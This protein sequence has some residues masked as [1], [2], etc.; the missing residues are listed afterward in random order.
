VVITL[1]VQRTALDRE[2]E[3]ASKSV[4]FGAN[5]Q[6]GSFEGQ[7]P[8]H[9]HDRL[10]PVNAGCDGSGRARNAPAD[11]SVSSKGSN[12]I[13]VMVTCSTSSELCRRRQRPRTWLPSMLLP[14]LTSFC[15]PEHPCGGEK[16]GG[17]VRVVEG[18]G[19][20]TLPRRPRTPEVSYVPQSFISI[21][22]H[23]PS[24]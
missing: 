19:G 18:V 10:D 24:P 4:V 1:Q 22:A 9:G 7:R 15:S 5:S 23:W 2:V 20:A 14:C 13:H 6:A 16:R 12:V 11:L 21:A 8:S 3:H 17:P